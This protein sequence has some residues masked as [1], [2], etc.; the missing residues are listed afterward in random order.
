MSKSNK[1]QKNKERITYIINLDREK[2][3]ETAKENTKNINIIEDCKKFCRNYSNKDFKKYSIF[4]LKNICAEGSGLLDTY[5]I[6]E[7]SKQENAGFIIQLEYI[8]MSA[9]YTLVSKQMENTRQKTV[10]FNDKLTKT[11]YNAKRLEEDAKIRT[12]EIKHIKSD[13]KS[14][15]TT[16]L[17]IV[18]AFSIIPTAI[19]AITKIDTNYILPFMSSIILF[20]M[21]MV[22]F[23]YS[24]YQDKIKISTWIVFILA[25]IICIILWIGAIYNFKDIEK[26]IKEE[27]QSNIQE[28]QE[29]N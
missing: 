13:I 29:E 9:N 7:E 14:I 12:E 24:I 2:I 16:I 19:T 8:I 3:K 6:T 22:I 25:I 27:Q 23:I 11:T 10:E 21:F 4:R 15:I 5:F 26:E 28:M 17:A 1:S 18:L 20:G